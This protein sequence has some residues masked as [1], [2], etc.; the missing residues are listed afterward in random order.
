VGTVIA[1]AAVSLVM[2]P[3]F[4]LR[5]PP[6]DT[7]AAPRA[8]AVAPDSPAAPVT[9]TAPAAAVAAKKQPAPETIPEVRTPA[10][11]LPR[12]HPPATSARRVRPPVAKAAA[13][14]AAASPE[15]LLKRAQEQFDLGETTS[16]LALASQAAAVGA[17]AP[18]HV[19]MGKVMMSERRYAEAEQHFAEAVRLDPGDAKAARLLAFVRET[20]RSGP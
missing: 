14:P 8:E 11:P 12:V 13:R 7:A 1:A 19:L 16:A 10:E 9:P 4:V 6:P 18:A 15:E 17:G 20:R 2:V 3:Y 5:G